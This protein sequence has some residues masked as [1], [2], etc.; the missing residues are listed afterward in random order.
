[1]S[2]TLPS[3][4]QLSKAPWFL[5]S[6]LGSAFN[7]LILQSFSACSASRVEER[8]LI[9]ILKDYNKKARPVQK[10]TDVVD[11]LVDIALPQLMKVVSA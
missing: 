1:M 2:F 5:T 7:P 3:P 4:P 6:K 8:L 11:I 9:T 10:E